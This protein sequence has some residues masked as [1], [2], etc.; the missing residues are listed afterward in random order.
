MS[1]IF[2]MRCITFTKINTM[3][4][5]M[6][7]IQKTKKFDYKKTRLT[8]DYQCESEEKNN[9]LVKNIIKKN[10]LQNQ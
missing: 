3:K 7:S 8:D 10:H 4:K 2:L 9:R 5:K 6:A 1:G